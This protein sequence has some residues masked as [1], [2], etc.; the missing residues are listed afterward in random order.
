MSQ[1]DESIEAMV[2]HNKTLNEVL[3]SLLEAAF[4]HED[5]STLIF[6][7]YPDVYDDLDSQGWTRQQLIRKLI[8]YTKKNGRVDD[9]LRVVEERNPYQYERFT[10]FITKDFSKGGSGI[11]TIIV[12]MENDNKLIIKLLRYLAKLLEIDGGIHTIRVTKGSLN[13]TVIL[14]I[15]AIDKLLVLHADHDR[16]L[17][18]QRIK[19]VVLVEPDLREV[20]LSGVYLVGA[21]L[22]RSDLR[23]ADLS[24]ANMSRVN[25]FRADIRSAD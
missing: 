3:R 23:K 12:E 6:D 5:L 16:R 20:L 18:D 2:P 10:P 22:T 11:V 25:L 13:I 1:T 14:P 15:E 9:L 7:R 21:D 4:S 24:S 17:I 8:T 19:Y